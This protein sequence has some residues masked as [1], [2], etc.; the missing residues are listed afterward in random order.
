[1][2]RKDCRIVLFETAFAQLFLDA[3]W[4]GSHASLSVYDK[5]DSPA[6]FCVGMP[7]TMFM[8]GFHWSLGVKSNTEQDHLSKD[9]PQHPPQPCL[10]YL[11]DSWL[12]TSPNQFRGAMVFSFVL[13]VVM[14]AISASRRWILQTKSHNNI[15]FRKS[16]LVIIYVL[17]AFLGYVIMFVAMM[18]SLELFLSVSAGFAVGNLL[19]V[20]LLPFPVQRP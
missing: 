4:A 14:E 12:L 17:Q 7:M 19:F 15:R 3:V 8:D 1:M 20:R 6:T 5:D 18:Y 16:L 10:T 2:L 13:A 11:F 9:Y